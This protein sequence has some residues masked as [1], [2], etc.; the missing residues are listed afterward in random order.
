MQQINIKDY[1]IVRQIQKYMYGD[2]FLAKDLNGKEVL[3]RQLKKGRTQYVI[4]QEKQ[5][6]D[7]HFDHPNVL[8]YLGT[9]ESEDSFYFITEKADDDLDQ[10]LHAKYPLSTE[11]ILHL[12][13]ELAKGMKYIHE[14]GF[15]H[16]DLKPSNLLLKHNGENE[17]PTLIISEFG[18]SRKIEERM[19]DVVGTPM[20]CA[21]EIM[22]S[23]IGFKNGEIVRLVK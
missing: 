10:Y 17:F 12:F 5:I 13:G 15:I 2:M 21:P 6:A 22:R 11:L 18:F 14:K 7:M 3:L 9:C 19:N 23:I 1:T 20:F 16:R 8:K 4:D